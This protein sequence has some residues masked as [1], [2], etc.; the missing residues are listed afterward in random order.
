VVVLDN[1]E[2][3]VACDAVWFVKRRGAAD[4]VQ[5]RLWDR[6]QIVR[7]GD[8]GGSAGTELA[9]EEVSAALRALRYCAAELPL[10]DDERRLLVR[11]ESL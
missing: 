4:E 9:S 2:I 10:D 6:L 11:L 5:Q 8:Y 3:E 1:D 7:S